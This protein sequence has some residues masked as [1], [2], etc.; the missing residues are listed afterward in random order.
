MITVDRNQ[1][2]NYGDGEKRYYG[3]TTICHAM[4][5]V[6]PYGDEVAMQRGQDLHVIFALS[7]WAYAGRCKPPS[8][9]SMY[10][11][12]YQSMQTWI[13]TAKP[14]PVQVERPSV[15]AIPG[16][17]FAGTPDLLAWI[18]YRGHRVLALVDLKSGQKARWHAIQV[19][20][21]SKLMLYRDAKALGVLYIHEDGRPGTYEPVKP[22]PRDWAGF[23]SALNL[24]I[25]REAA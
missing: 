17:P 12:Y 14:E 3:V 11:S 25:W 23:Q 2:R 16:M 22:K 24:L 6:D 8:V 20:A 15:S 13:Q 18:L 5:G 1:P 9:P 10:Q 4:G 21:Y 19:H 7:V